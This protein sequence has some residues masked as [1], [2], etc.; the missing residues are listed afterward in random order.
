[1]K[2]FVVAFVTAAAAL[3]AVG[4]GFSAEPEKPAKPALKT[5]MAP[6]PAA[7]LNTAQANPN[8]G[9]KPDTVK[10]Q[11]PVKTDAPPV[12]KPNPPAAAEVKKDQPP[13]TTPPTTTPP[14]TT[15]PA[16]T[17][18]ATTPP[19]AG[20]NGPKDATVVKVAP[21]VKAKAKYHRKRHIKRG[22]R[23]HYYG[24]RYARRR[25]YHHRHH[26]YRH[27][28][29][30]HRYHRGYHRH[31]HYKKHVVAPSKVT[32]KPQ[33]PKTTPEPK[34]DGKPTTAK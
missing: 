16:T 3:L 6:K 23:K 15:P 31:K 28:H 29:H 12:V 14:T 22:Y 33:T 9:N 20:P 5:D 8:T 1:M 34:K 32:S 4:N 24:H 19:A 26:Y 7:G 2:K 21:K 18:P 10:K 13:K 25:H 11:D 17:P 27:R 30:Y